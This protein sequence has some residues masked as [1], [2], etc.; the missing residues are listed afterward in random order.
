MSIRLADKDVTILRF[1]LGDRVECAFGNDWKPGMNYHD[2]KRSNKLKQT[3]YFLAEVDI[4][5]TVTRTDL[6]K[7]QKS[8]QNEN[9][10]N[11]SMQLRKANEFQSI[12]PPDRYTSPTVTLKTV[13]TPAHSVPPYAAAHAAA[14]PRPTTRAPRWRASRRLRVEEPAV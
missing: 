5:P 1:A 8:L 13:T 4:V 2:A 6:E 3:V 10:H 12:K 11:N 9:E 7:V 14:P